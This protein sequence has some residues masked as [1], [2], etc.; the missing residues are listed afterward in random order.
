MAEPNKNTNTRVS[1]DLL[2]RARHAILGAYMLHPEPEGRVHI[3]EDQELIERVTR[4]TTEGVVELA[5][6]HVIDTCEMSKPG[7]SGIHALDQ[8][9]SIRLTGQE[10]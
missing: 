2:F 3:L 5:L 6:N 1:R 10:N 4:M 8:Y 9:R 7:L